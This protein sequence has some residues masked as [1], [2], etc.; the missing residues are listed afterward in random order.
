MESISS[1]EDTEEI[2]IQLGDI[3][4]IIAPENEILHFI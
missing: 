1:T 2:N 4:E 3:I